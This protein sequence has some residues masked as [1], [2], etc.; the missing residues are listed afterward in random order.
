[1]NA[2]KPMTS[3]DAMALATQDTML[4]PRFYTT[5]FDA[6]D[7]IDVSP[8][9]EEWDQLIAD[10]L[11]DPNKKHF[12]HNDSFKGVIE[13]LEPELREEFKDFLVSS[14]T[15]EFSGCVLYAEIAKRTKNPDVKQLFKLLA[16]DESRHAGFINES[17][18]D[19]GIGV[20]L[21]FLTRTKKYT[22]FKPKFIWYAVY[23][24]EKIGYARYITI[25]R[26]LA[27][28]PQNKFHPIF[29]WF[30]EWCND[31]FRHGEAFAMLLRAD[32]KLLKG[33]NKLW[34]RFFLL[35]VYATMY[36]R[37]HNREVFHRALGV[38]PTEYDYKVFTI[39]NQI[40][41]QVFPV[42]LD[43]DS[44]AFRK[45][46]EALRQSALKIEEGKAQGGLGGLAKRVSGAA[47]AG[48]NFAKMYRQ[49]TK[50]NSLPQSIRLQPAW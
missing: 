23:L 22:Y 34:I 42:E 49:R 5:D 43:I 21:G 6:L 32:P 7:A 29:D 41:R 46:M 38:D 15:S 48:W 25:Y 40:S 35:S 37:D 11:G 36:V 2:Y 19:A 17:L 4:T 13:N 20:D 27:A 10:M 31:E 47:G 14:M 26:H 1:M 8:V 30:E 24:S 44:P 28:N 45:N 9:R 39:C 50:P 16:R 18:K 33:H 12:K 3:E